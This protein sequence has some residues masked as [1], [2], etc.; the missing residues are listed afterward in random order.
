MFLATH[1]IWSYYIP[2]TDHG[3]IIISKIYFLKQWFLV[4]KMIEYT[5]CTYGFQLLKHNLIETEK[6]IG[7]FSYHSVN[8]TTRSSW[9]AYCSITS[10]INLTFWPPPI[11]LI[12]SPPRH[13]SPW[14]RTYKWNQHFIPEQNSNDD[15]ITK[16]GSHQQFT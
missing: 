10:F 9:L 14:P 13:S 8:K 16:T 15:S 12:P 4:N 6:S 11:L 5:I 2:M 7:Y 1:Q 3:F